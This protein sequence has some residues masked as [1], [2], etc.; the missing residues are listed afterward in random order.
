MERLLDLR[1]GT[2][3]ASLILHAALKREESRG[4]HF[5]EDFPEQDNDH[6]QGHLQ[7]HR[8]AEGREEWS[9]EPV[10]GADSRCRNDE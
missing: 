8:L 7:V 10:A 3:T 4:A 1:L 9:F 5:R 2:T 6:W